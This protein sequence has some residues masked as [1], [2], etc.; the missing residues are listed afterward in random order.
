MPR[1]FVNNQEQNPANG[2]ESWGLLLD[3]L[4]QDAIGRGD[5]VTEVRFDGVDEPTFWQPEEAGRA[6]SGVE[7]IEVQTMPSRALLDE[8]LSRGELA[9]T[10]LASAAARTGVAFRGT[11]LETANNALADIGEGVRSL[12]S[13]SKIAAAALELTL[14]ELEWNGGSGAVQIGELTRLLASIVEAQQAQDWLTVADILDYDFQ[15]ALEG[16]LGVFE[17]LRAAADA[18]AQPQ[19]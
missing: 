10:T 12:T 5:V 11:D 8:A 13:I 16:W 1:L 6:L 14:E 17:T 15:P 9:V 2:P 18:Q 19:N 7:L 3:R 4:E